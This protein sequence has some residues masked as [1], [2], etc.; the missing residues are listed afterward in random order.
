MAAFRRFLIGLIILQLALPPAAFADLKPKTPSFKDR[1]SAI[2][3]SI[4]KSVKGVLGKVRLPGQKNKSTFEE[5]HGI[6]APGGVP[7]ANP[8]TSSFQDPLLNKMNVASY[9]RQLNTSAV[10]DI[11]FK[12]DT[13]SPLKAKVST[14]FQD[15]SEDLHLDNDR[16]RFAKRPDSPATPDKALTIY[17]QQLLVGDK[18]LPV[19]GHQV[20]LESQDDLLVYAHLKHFPSLGEVFNDPVSIKPETSDEAFYEEGAQKALRDRLG[21]DIEIKKIASELAISSRDHAPDPKLA[22]LV[23]HFTYDTSE[24]EAE[25]EV[26]ARSRGKMNMSAGTSGEVLNVV[27]SVY[28]QTQPLPSALPSNTV[29]SVKPVVTPAYNTRFQGVP[30]CDEAPPVVELIGRI[31]GEE[32]SLEINRT[33]S[34]LPT[35]DQKVPSFPVELMTLRQDNEGKPHLVTENVD[36]VFGNGD[37]AKGEVDE[38]WQRPAVSAHWGATAAA[39]FFFKHFD[40][41]EGFGNR[42]SKEV[43]NIILKKFEKPTARVLPSI[44]EIQFDDGTSGGFGGCLDALGEEYSHGIFWHRVKPITTGRGEIDAI[45]EGFAHIF[46][47]LIK[48]YALGPKGIKTSVPPELSRTYNGANYVKNT[49]CSAGGYCRIDDAGIE[50]AC[51]ADSY[52]DLP[53]QNKGVL[54]QW[55]SLLSSDGMKQ[56]TYRLPGS[57]TETS[58]KVNGIGIESASEILFK[59][60][61]LLPR[62]ASFYDL[63]LLTVRMAQNLFGLDSQE[64]ISVEDAWYAVNVGGKKR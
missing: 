11:S 27:T 61:Q 8:A 2:T 12:L 21:N 58:Y 45:N 56:G 39:E 63:R 26:V 7:D 1:L 41:Y 48:A 49:G 29:N 35:K 55:Y 57:E 42:K 54:L 64:A 40:G 62:T 20:L 47:T 24:G 16:D 44:N 31:E 52:C 28:Y 50:T 3:E 15:F 33:G 59:A 32:L 6:K 5:G 38:K 46:G 9:H 30:A 43:I 14:F 19:L 17:D 18:T 60:T 4:T 37:P 10:A 53:H 13:A 23:W 34:E 51:P 36:G 22:V 25:V